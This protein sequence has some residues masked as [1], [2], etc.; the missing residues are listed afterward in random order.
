MRTE[1]NHVLGFCLFHLF[2][3][4][5]VLIAAF[6]WVIFLIHL[7]PHHISSFVSYKS[8]TSI[9]YHR[10]DSQMYC[11]NFKTSQASSKLRIWQV[12][13]TFLQVL[14]IQLWI[15]VWSRVWTWRFESS[16][17]QYCVIFHVS[18]DVAKNTL[19]A[20]VLYLVFTIVW[21]YII[22]LY[23]IGLWSSWLFRTLNVCILS[24]PGFCKEPSAKNSRSNLQS[25]SAGS[26][27]ARVCHEVATENP[28]AHGEKRGHKGAGTPESS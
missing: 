12:L 7:L 28:A 24:C 20:S 23:C 9:W 13:T 22:F 26:K 5:S 11:S 17:N 2:A 3:I 25:T 19:T 1:R 15:S 4:V 8:V 6:I 10:G 14:C 21:F 18:S 16:G 27:L